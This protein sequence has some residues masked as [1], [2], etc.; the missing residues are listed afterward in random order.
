MH[1]AILLSSLAALAAG[2]F[3][4]GRAEFHDLQVLVVEATAE[5]LSSLNT[6][7]LM[8]TTASNSTGPV[9]MINA[10]IPFNGVIVLPVVSFLPYLL[11]SSPDFGT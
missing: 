9:T 6:T 2:T 1:P 3:A 10:T 11:L 7:S 5:I 8:L 4:D